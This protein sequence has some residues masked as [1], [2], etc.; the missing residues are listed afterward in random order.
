M[1]LINLVQQVQQKTVEHGPESTDFVSG[2]DSQRG[3]IFM[4]Q[5]KT[6]EIVF[7]RR[8]PG[9]RFWMPMLRLLLAA[10][11]LIAVAHAG[12]RHDKNVSDELLEKHHRALAGQGSL[13]ELVD[14][15]VQFNSSPEKRHFDK[16][17]GLGANIAK[18]LM[19]VKGGSFRLPVSVVQALADDP[20]VAY[21]STDR[22]IRPSSTDRYIQSVRADY[23]NSMGW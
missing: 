23:A 9:K 6:N 19:S 5:R 16:M 17:K 14:V 1:L 2:K 12:P 18:Q 8:R 3:T 21:V 11:L 20:E 7:D 15:I 13:D 10:V 22:P 4:T